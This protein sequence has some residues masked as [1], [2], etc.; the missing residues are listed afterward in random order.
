MFQLEES[1]EATFLR[2]IEFVSPTKIKPQKLLR[3][4]FLLLNR[5]FEFKTKNRPEIDLNEVPNLAIVFAQIGVW[6][7]SL[8]CSP[9]LFPWTV[10]PVNSVGSNSVR[11]KS[12]S[13]LSSSA[14]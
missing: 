5:T 14:S 3:P 12:F 1:L 13:W 7:V 4:P 10:A 9:G 2:P 8:V 6:T 11:S